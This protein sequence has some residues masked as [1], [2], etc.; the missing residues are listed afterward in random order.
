MLCLVAILSLTLKEQTSNFIMCMKHD[1]VTMHDVFLWNW[2]KNG[3]Y[4]DDAIFIASCIND[5]IG[6]IIQWSLAKE[7]VIPWHGIPN[8]KDA[9]A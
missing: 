4:C 7:K 1:N 9:L 8:S 3:V 6:N 2:L 5:A